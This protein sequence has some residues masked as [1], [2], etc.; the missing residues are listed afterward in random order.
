M[1]ADGYRT[2]QGI[3]FPKD[4]SL[5]SALSAE[6]SQA[7]PKGL[8]SASSLG[9]GEKQLVSISHQDIKAVTEAL[10]IQRYWVEKEP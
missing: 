1:K 8:S 3:I 9:L 4:T 7:Q 5:S 6:I 10:V 2:T